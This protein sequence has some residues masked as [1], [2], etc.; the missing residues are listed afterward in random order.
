MTQTSSSAIST[1]QLQGFEDFIHSTMQD[2]KLPG[3]AIAIIKNGEV[4]LSQGFGKRD[5]A[6]GL[7]VTPQTLFPIGS[8]TKAFT[9]TSMGI[10]V[11]EG[12]LDWDTPV[13]TYLPTFKM[14][15][16]FATER[17]TPRDL[18]THRS[19]LPRHDL[20]W[21][22]STRSRKELV[23]SLQYLE[24]SKDFRT[25]WQ[26]QNLMYMTAGYLVGELADQSWEE[27]VQQRILIPLGMTTST[28]STTQAKQTLD[29]SMP[30]KKEEKGEIKEAIFYDTWQAIAPAGALVSNV[31]EMSQWLLLQLNKG[32]HGDTQII[33]E[34]Q[35]EQIHTPQ[36]IMP[37]PRK[38]RE[39]SH[40]SYAMG[41]AVTMYKGHLMLEHG[42]G[43]NGFSALTTLLPDDNIGIVAL[44][45]RE[46]CPAHNI[47]MFN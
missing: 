16:A 39:L 1:Q 29:F 8:C 24:P 9:T 12:K 37:G 7:D 44:S 45:N 23:E 28:F 17:M 46:G 31:V 15:D 41:W 34:T 21:Y 38:Y 19:G 47:I 6:Q 14:Y 10:L 30:Y 11:D 22:N 42:G 18:V 3:L 20:A 2:W 13:R 40:N 4:I 36:I 27:F 43:I 5:I 32:K 33:S 25:I 26:Y 35:L